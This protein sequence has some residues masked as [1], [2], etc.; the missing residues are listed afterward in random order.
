MVICWR[1]KSWVFGVWLEWCLEL[2]WCCKLRKL[3]NYCSGVSWG[4]YSVCST[5][6]SSVKSIRKPESDYVETEASSSILH[7][8]K[9]HN[10]PSDLTSTSSMLQSLPGIT[11]AVAIRWWIVRIDCYITK[12]QWSVD[13]WEGYPWRASSRNLTYKFAYYSIPVVVT[14]IHILGCLMFLS[15]HRSV[16][17]DLLCLIV[18][19]GSV[20]IMSMWLIKCY[21]I[22]YLSIW[23]LSVKE[24]AHLQYDEIKMRGLEL[25]ECSMMIFCY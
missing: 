1:Y 2:Y 15:A 7:T 9:I 5:T 22:H 8:F 14:C 3:S 24:Q 4:T 18:Y 16:D 13:L 11:W 23:N 25:C 10:G 21:L 6:S 17:F 19:R 12:F 20:C